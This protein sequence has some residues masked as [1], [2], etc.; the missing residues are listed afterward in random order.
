[1]APIPRTVEEI[2]IDYRARRTALVNALTRDADEFYSLCDPG[3]DNLCLFGHGDES[4]EVA[5]PAEEV[6]AELP[7]PVLGINFF[8]DRKSRKDWFSYVA[9]HSDCW[10]LAVAFYLAFRLD[11]FQRQRLFSL[12]NNLPSVFEA[13]TKWNKLRITNVPTEGGSSSKSTQKNSTNLEAIIQCRICE[14]HYNPNE[15]WIGCDVCECW[16][17]GKCVDITPEEAETIEQYECPSCSLKSN[18]R[19]SRTTKEPSWMKYYCTI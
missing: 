19:P 7:E 3:M 9:V 17:H 4:W 1:M 15:F 13:V 2:F 16:F 5:L 14:G 10:L 18:T 12:I 6:P 11:K 8:R